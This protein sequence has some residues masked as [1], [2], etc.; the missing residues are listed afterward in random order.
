MDTQEF[1]RLTKKI[2]TLKEQK[3]RTEGAME[4]IVTSW[5]TE[6]GVSTPEE[7]SALVDKKT[8]EL[9]EIDEMIEEHYTELKGLTNWGLV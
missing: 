4:S 1:E 8:A 9:S 7:L 6:Y 5:K 2:A 3:A